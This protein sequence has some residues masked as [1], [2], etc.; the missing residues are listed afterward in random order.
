MS[1]LQPVKV[2]QKAIK[3]CKYYNPYYKDACEFRH[4]HFPHLNITKYVAY[5]HHYNQTNPPNQQ[6]MKTYNQCKTLYASRKYSKCVSILLELLKIHPFN[7]RFNLQIARCY[8]KLKDDRLSSHH[9]RRIIAICPDNPVHHLSYAMYLFESNLDPNRARCH[10]VE[11][12]HLAKEPENKHAKKVEKYKIHTGFA[13][14]LHQQWR[15]NG[16]QEDIDNARKHFESALKYDDNPR[17]N[18]YFARL[19]HEIGD[20]EKA[21][22]HYKQSIRVTHSV[23]PTS[24]NFRYGIF[25]KQCK[26][27]EQ[28]EEQFIICLQREPEAKSVLYE[29]GLMLCKNMKV[30]DLGLNYLRRVRSVGSK[31]LETY[32]YYKGL[33]YGRNDG[34]KEEKKRKS[35]HC[36]S[37]SIGSRVDQV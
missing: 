11:A 18:H 31:Y 33:F 35:R 6:D 34:R 21:E 36:L 7:E 2:D 14:F 27:Y 22:Y 8:D 37:A 13:Q 19:L 1:S 32:E 26:R 17:T 30:Y 20:L 28:A 16:N 23:S 12:L 25:L 5:C 9:H 29:Y 3:I 15:I 24:Y 10:F 4:C